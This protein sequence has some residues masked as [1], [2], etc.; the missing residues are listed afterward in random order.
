[1]G[2]LTSLSRRLKVSA[3]V[4]F[5]LLQLIQGFTFLRPSL[6]STQKYYLKQAPVGRHN[7]RYLNPY[8]PLTESSEGPLIEEDDDDI[9][10]VV[11]FTGPRQMI[12]DAVSC[13]K[14]AY[15][16][17]IDRF[18]NGKK[19]TQD[20]WKQF[21]RLAGQE[22]VLLVCSIASLI[23]AAFCE[24][25][26]PH[27]SA[28]ALNAIA[29]HQ[30]YPVFLKNLKSM[31]VFGLVGPL[32]TGFRGVFFWLSGIRVV[33][34]LRLLLFSAMLDKDISYF[35]ETETGVL[36]SRLS[37][38]TKK[39]ENVVGFHFNIL[40]RELIQAAGGIAYLFHLHRRLAAVAVSALLL[41]SSATSLYSIVS[42]RL[43]RGVQDALAS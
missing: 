22:K 42:R 43:S 27:Y 29:I 12:G 2:S 16:E 41:T 1:M 7:E 18:F 9:F 4:C 26:F 28:Q 10:S 5:A 39:L 20:E 36:T 32:L 23:L 33:T 30:D 11:E 14:L 6:L 35:D 17:A 34:R 31:V 15:I 37:S 21:G 25:A 40:M 13:A 19:A 38:D 24:V 3:L 8:L